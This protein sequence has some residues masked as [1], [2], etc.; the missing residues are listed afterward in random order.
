MK[1]LLVIVLALLCYSVQAQKWGQEF[2]LNYLYANP[3]GGMGRII[4]HGDGVTLNYGLV[5]PNGRFSFGAEINLAQYG[6]DKS[7]QEYTMDDGSVAPMD[8]VVSNSFANIM[9]YSRWYLSTKGLLRPYLTG[10][11]GYTG[12][13][14]DLNIYDPDD[15]DQCKPIDN[16]VLYSDGTMVAVVGAGV[17]VDFASVFKKLRTG[18]FYL[19]SSINFTQG[20]QVRY[21]SEDADAHHPYSNTP[22]SEHVMA[23]FINTETQIVHQHHVG[24]L[25]TSPV[26]M[27]E[28]RVGFSMTISR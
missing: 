24:H 26:Q 25:Y 5:I 1:N 2:G 18:R 21:M 7:R 19:E 16:D 6:R 3:V 8:I 27:T 12:F 10:K 17:K 23:N 20:G 14:T 11:L 4:Q 28:L 13:S 9:V 22:D 15:N